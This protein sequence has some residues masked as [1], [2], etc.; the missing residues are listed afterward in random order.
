MVRRRGGLDAAHKLILADGVSELC[1]VSRLQRLPDAIRGGVFG[2]AGAIQSLGM[3]LGMAVCSPLFDKMAAAHVVTLLHGVPLSL[4]A[5][6]TVLS[7]R[8]LFLSAA[9]QSELPSV[10]PRQTA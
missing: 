7:L 6:F 3:A 10:D 5:L 8:R 4:A 9:A 2:A 1:F